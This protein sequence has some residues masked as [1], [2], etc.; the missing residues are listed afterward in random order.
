MV[1]TRCWALARAHARQGVRRLGVA[2]REWHRGRTTAR[3]ARDAVDNLLIAWR[4][5]R[6]RPGFALYVPVLRPCGRQ[7]RQL[8]ARVLP[9][10]PARWHSARTCTRM[11]W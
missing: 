5:H 1:R 4:M 7:D 3:P 8:L 11:G 9:L 6:A 2:H 10:A